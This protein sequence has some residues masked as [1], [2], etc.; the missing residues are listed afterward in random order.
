MLVECKI[1]GDLAQRF[2][3]VMLVYSEYW[4]NVRL[5]FRAQNLESYE[6]H[7]LESN[8]QLCDSESEEY[9][10]LLLARA[11]RRVRKIAR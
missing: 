6:N 1:E 11:K 3:S 2:K 9:F 5:S 8:R 4:D 7:V 10:D